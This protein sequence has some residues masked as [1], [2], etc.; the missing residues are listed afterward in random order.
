MRAKIAEIVCTLFVPVCQGRGRR[1][2][3]C[4]HRASRI[5]ILTKVRIHSMRRGW[6]GAA[7]KPCLPMRQAPREWIPAFAGMTVRV[8]CVPPEMPAFAGMT[9][10]CGASTGP[11][12]TDAGLRPAP[13]GLKLPRLLPLTLSRPPLRG[14]FGGPA[15]MTTTAHWLH[16][17]LGL[18]LVETSVDDVVPV[19][20]PDAPRRT[21]SPAR[22]PMRPCRWPCSSRAAEQVSPLPEREG[23]GMGGGTRYSGLTARGFRI[24]TQYPPQPLPS[25]E[26]LS[27]AAAPPHAEP[28]SRF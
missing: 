24:A 6:P 13:R 22:R 27:V 26:G 9:V 16:L 10:S 8:L 3:A 19:Q 23:P 15:I 14:G 5:V 1:E 2:R 7:S 25:R 18:P 20:E 21:S 12:R 4:V 28:G 11:A 17:R